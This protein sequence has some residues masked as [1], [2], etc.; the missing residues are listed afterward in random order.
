MPV[1]GIPG[2]KSPFDSGPRQAVL[3]DVVLADIIVIVKDAEAMTGHWQVN[4]QRDEREQQA[5]ETRTGHRVL[6]MRFCPGGKRGDKV[7][8]SKKTLHFP[9]RGVEIVQ[10]GNC[11]TPCRLDAISVPHDQVCFI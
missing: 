7:Y 1:A 10:A 2:G 11:S 6:C 9:A 4:Q 3:D 5:H 8:F